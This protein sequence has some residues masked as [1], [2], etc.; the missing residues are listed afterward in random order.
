MPPYAGKVLAA[1]KESAVSTAYG[2]PS[3]EGMVAIPATGYD[4]PPDDGLVAW[5]QVAG[6]FFL[7]FNSWGTVNAFGVFQTYYHIGFLSDKSPSNISWIGSIQSFLLL[8]IGVITGP[9]YDA[10]YFRALI[11]TGTSLIVLGF[12]MTSLCTQYWQVILAQAICI[13]LGQGCLFI[14]SVAIIPQYF[15]NKKAFATGLASS[16]SSLGG[17]IYPIVFSQLQPRIGFSWA[18]R[19]LGFISLT[20]C[21]VSI[22]VMRVRQI[23][24]QRRSLVEFAAFK[25]TPY[26]LFCLAMFFCYAGAFGPIYYISSYAIDTRVMTARLA[27]YL[28]PILNAASVPG[29]IITGFLAN[30]MGPVNLLIPTALTIGI[31]ALCWIG[32]HSTGGLIVF[33]ILYGFFSGGVV[34][35]PSVGDEDGN[36]LCALQSGKSLR[37]TDL[38]R[39]SGW[40]WGLGRGGIVFWVYTV[41]YWSAFSL[42]TMGSGRDEFEDEGLRKAKER[43]TVRRARFEKV[44]APN[45]QLE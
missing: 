1:R 31:I 45:A 39:D 22:S 24:K 12:M 43:W 23:P 20:T 21:L 34:S 2:A 13:G 9:L 25:E 28:L 8:V 16:G 40:D 38:R 18:T 5:L 32:I 41:S 42:H 44:R 6:S 4:D 33:A 11:L 27:F 15:T 26:S 10:G 19:V 29:R 17:V 14:P 7:F 37:Y 36:V 30:T 35:L 3:A